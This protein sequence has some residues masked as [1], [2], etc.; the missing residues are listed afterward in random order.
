MSP[1]DIADLSVCSCQTL[2]SKLST[3]KV[4][5]AHNIDY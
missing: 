5:K 1:K 4:F 2:N 3:L